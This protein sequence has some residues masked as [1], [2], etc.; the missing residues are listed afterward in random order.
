MITLNQPISA[1]AIRDLAQRLTSADIVGNGPCGTV[2]KAVV[3]QV[4]KHVALKKIRLRSGSSASW[5]TSHRDCLKEMKRVEGIR[6]AGIV[7]V[8]G[9]CQDGDWSYM[10]YE[11]M[12][13]RSLGDILHGSSTRAPQF[14]DWNTRYLPTGH[15]ACIGREAHVYMSLTQSFLADVLCMHDCQ[16]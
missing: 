4:G 10:V 14:M 3:P 16:V 8:L 7:R 13:N 12:P 6:H 1:R 11:H 5:D 9:S 15:H 2:Y